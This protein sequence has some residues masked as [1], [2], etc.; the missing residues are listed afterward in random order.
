MESRDLRER[1]AGIQ[2]GP[3]RDD[4]ISRLNERLT[5]TVCGF[6]P[7]PEVAPGLRFAAQSENRKGPI[8]FR[9]VSTEPYISSVFNSNV[10][11]KRKNISA[12]FP[13]GT[14]ARAAWNFFSLSLSARFEK[15]P[16]SH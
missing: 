14:V 12:K 11:V 2:K 5:T 3:E 4:T 6:V 8:N 16:F 1:R 15:F 7:L 10:S 9:K 13:A